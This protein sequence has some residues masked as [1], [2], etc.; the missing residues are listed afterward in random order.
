MRFRLRTLLL[1]IVPVALV[2]GGGRAW[3]N[4]RIAEGLR[5]QRLAVESPEMTF[6]FE[7]DG[8]RVFHSP[9]SRT[10]W[11][12][13]RA[14]SAWCEDARDFA[15]ALQR[16]QEFP[17]VEVLYVLGRQIIPELDARKVPPAD[18]LELLRRQP[19]LKRLV[20]DASIRG[21]PLE[22]HAKLYMPSDRARLEAALPELEI[23][24]IEVN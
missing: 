6:T 8:P 21:A 1:F 22:P 3:L 11:A 23:R 20:V 15:G 7:Y 12:F 13:R 4:R 17:D 16:L 10:S 2:L 18:C 9:D 14:R 24:W 5:Q 19:S